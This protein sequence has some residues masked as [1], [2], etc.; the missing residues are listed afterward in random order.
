MLETIGSIETALTIL[1]TASDKEF[2]IDFDLAW[3]WVEYSRKDSALRTLKDN[4][5]LSTD[6]LH[7]VVENDNHNVIAIR[8]ATKVDKYFLSYEAFV[9]FCMLSQTPRGKEVRHY[10]IMAEARMRKLQAQLAGMVSQFTEVSTVLANTTPYQRLTAYAD[11]LGVKPQQVR[12]VLLQ[13]GWNGSYGMYQHLI[14]KGYGD[15]LVSVL[16]TLPI[17]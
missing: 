5:D 11:T 7:I 13:M 14:L 3:Q 10:F 6:Y 4:F 16:K 17:Y 1:Q 15:K 12:A 9:A 8:K 2:P